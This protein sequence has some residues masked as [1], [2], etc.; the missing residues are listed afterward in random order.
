[1]VRRV[2]ES[3][4][5]PSSNLP[6]DILHLWCQNDTLGAPAKS[7]EVPVHY[8]YTGGTNSKTDSWGHIHTYACTHVHI[9]VHALTCVRTH[10][11]C[12]NF[13]DCD[14]DIVCYLGQGGGAEATRDRDA[15]SGAGE[16]P[17]GERRR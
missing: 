9:R 11:Q 1:M 14:N 15:A 6:S 5:A 13:T 17:P 7:F 12:I 10:I 3:I 16:T 4:K 2:H 8:I